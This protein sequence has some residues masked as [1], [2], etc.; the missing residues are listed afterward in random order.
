MSTCYVTIDPMTLDQFIEL[1]EAEGF[2]ITRPEPGSFTSGIGVVHPDGRGAYAISEEESI[3][4]DLHVG[5]LG[6]PD[7]DAV[8]LA[9]EGSDEYNEITGEG[10][11]DDAAEAEIDE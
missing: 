2:E 9:C 6:D 8:D 5:M 4:G 10:D 11:L 3:H 1:A 7:I